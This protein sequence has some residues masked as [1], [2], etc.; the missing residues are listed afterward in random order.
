[1]IFEIGLEGYVGIQAEQMVPRNNDKKWSRDGVK[2][3]LIENCN[4]SSL[5][6][7]SMLRV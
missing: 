4:L 7:H 5:I 6:D 2:P 3:K 1:M